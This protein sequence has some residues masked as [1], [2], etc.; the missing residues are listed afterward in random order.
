M[1]SR[2]PYGEGSYQETIYSLLC[3]NT[4][5]LVVAGHDLSAQIPVSFNPRGY[6]FCDANTSDE[7]EA[8]DSLRREMIFR[9]ER[10]IRSRIRKHTFDVVAGVHKD[11][12]QQAAD[13]AVHAYD[14]RGS[15][16]HTG[17]LTPAELSNGHTHALKALRMLLLAS[18]GVSE[19]DSVGA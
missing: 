12:A 13:M 7:Y 1:L 17:S 3:T 8:L 4:S 6:R 18:F 16:V 19:L 9:R 11:H 5:R 15:L 2:Q 14:L 10:S